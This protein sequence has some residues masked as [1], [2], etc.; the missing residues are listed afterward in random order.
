M[1]RLPILYWNGQGR[2]LNCPVNC[3]LQLPL[4]EVSSTKPI[5]TAITNCV[6]INWFQGFRLTHPTSGK[7]QVEGERQI[8]LCAQQ[9]HCPEEELPTGELC[10]AGTAGDV[11]N[12][13]GEDAAEALQAFS[14]CGGDVLAVTEQ[15][16]TQR[17]SFTGW[18]NR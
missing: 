6:W 3:L 15:A 17:S 8:V 10:P 16:H 9:P 13:P 14:L 4:L 5:Q 7:Q 1:T 11:L 2:E 18:S 12:T